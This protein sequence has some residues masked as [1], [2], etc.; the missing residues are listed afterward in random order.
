[1]KA[2]M[3]DLINQSEIRFHQQNLP[4]FAH[5]GNILSS[6]RNSQCLILQAE[7]GLGK[8]T[9]LPQYLL[10]EYAQSEYSQIY[11]TQPRKIAASGASKRVNEEFGSE[12]MATSCVYPSDFNEMSKF[13]IVYFSE[14]AFLNHLLSEI[15]N[16]VPLKN[17][18]GLVL[19]EAHERN[20]ET[21]VILALIKK[22]VLP[23]RPDFKLIITSATLQLE[24]LMNY[25]KCEIITIPGAM[26]PVEII[27]CKSY[28][29][30]FI[31]TVN[32]TIGVIKGKIVRS[33]GKETILVFFS[34]FDEINGAKN[35]ISNKV[36]L[37]NVEI[38]MLYGNLDFKEQ[39]DIVNTQS[40]KIRVVISTNI[41]ESSLTVP[42]VTCV[43]D[44][45]REKVSVS[46]QCKDYRVKF[47]TKM[48]A[49]QRKGRAGRTNPGVCYRVY[50]ENEYQEMLD[51]REPAIIKSHIGLLVLKFM[52]YGI[53]EIESLGLIDGPDPESIKATN[54]DLENL[55]MLMK[56]S[57][58]LNKITNIGNFCLDLEISPMLARFIYEAYFNYD[59][60]DEAAMLSSVLLCMDFIFLRTDYNEEIV[61]DM[62]ED[63][64]LHKDLVR[65]G[66]M[67]S[68]LFIFRQYY[69]L[70]CNSC[71]S[72]SPICTCAEIRKTW[73]QKFYICEKRIKVALKQYSDICNKLALKLQEH[74]YYF[75]EEEWA[76]EKQLAEMSL[77][78]TTSPR[79]QENLQAVIKNFEEFYTEFLQKAII[80]SF[81][82]NLAQY[83]GD[84]TID[85]GYLYIKTR[86]IVVNHP[87]SPLGKLMF[88]TP[89]KYV[90]F[91]EVSVTS[92]LFMKFITP[93]DIG[94]VKSICDNW[95]QS[96]NF[97]EEIEEP[98]GLVFQNIGPLYMREIFGPSGSKVQN[99][100]YSFK[101]KGINGVL[102]LPDV[103]KNCLKLRLP[104]SFREAGEQELRS[105]LNYKQTEVLRKNIVHIPFSKG[106]IL[107]IN[108]GGTVSELLYSEETLIFHLNDLK[109]YNNYSEALADVQ[110]TFE[111]Y[112][113]NYVKKFNENFGIVY[114][115]SVAQAEEAQKRLEQKPLI[116]KTGM[117]SQLVPY[118]KSLPQPCL[119]IR[120]AIQVNQLKSML[121]YYG[122]YKYINFKQLS[123]CAQAYIRY[124]SQNAT[125]SCFF[126]LSKWVNDEFGVQVSIQKLQ[127]GILVP[128]ELVNIG[129][130]EIVN[131]IEKINS[132]HDSDFHISGRNVM[133][134]YAEDQRLNMQ[135][136]EMIIDLVN[137]DIIPITPELMRCLEK[138]FITMPDEEN[139]TWKV[140]QQIYQVFCVF[141]H[142]RQS[143]A[144]YGLPHN[145]KY[146]IEQL[147]P[148]LGNLLKQIV[149]VTINYNSIKEM[150][151]IEL[152]KKKH[153]NELQVD[154]SIN[155]RKAAVSF[156]GIN[157]YINNVIE[158]L[159][160]E[161]KEIQNIENC[162][163]CT[164]FL[165][166]NIVI[167]S[168]CGHK[169]HSKCI[170]FQIKSSI[171]EAATGGFPIVCVICGHF[172]IHNDWCKALSYVELQALYH[173]ALIQFISNNEQFSH[174]ENPSCDFVY[175]VEQV[176]AQGNKR[177]CARC[178]GEYCIVCKKQI[179]GLGHE[180]NCEI[181]KMQIDDKENLKWIEEN[182]AVCPNCLVR[183]EKSK[184]CNHLNCPRCRTHFCFLCSMKID[185]FSPIEHYMIPNTK[186]FQK[187]IDNSH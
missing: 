48:S 156:T 77:N 54:T 11:C 23:K 106:M 166:E 39:Q 155:R 2:N 173:S 72:N 120:A 168:L 149:T 122:E 55:K 95:L 153:Y 121:E 14:Y 165:S 6:L 70:L 69:A 26:F 135:A 128:K 58:N 142:F 27:Y 145:R 181:K 81:F 150:R 112:Q 56:T 129:L 143:L 32:I 45:G 186:C 22:H 103:S 187:Y 185:E 64:L 139:V 3:Q 57:E 119:K 53:F 8:T 17:C 68:S 36:S 83:R 162:L 123:N 92:N 67:V 131:Y 110:N 85:A 29:N 35:I 177:K 60:G 101:K 125:D 61:E 104:A 174:C 21:D 180:I 43:V 37:E 50:T 71:L 179:F 134:I 33:T 9:Q 96:Q 138:H 127:Q 170:N 86:E 62:R 90:I 114:F 100:E 171:S 40:K 7:T 126:E 66:D 178:K 161:E 76:L 160:L 65:L 12:N 163:I 51:F 73:S 158:K 46:G 144:V 13:P 118:E 84:K 1:M 89:P 183:I 105:I 79:F 52:K 130:E 94:K 38:L 24:T 140:W 82:Q 97:S 146:A 157:Y 88:L 98:S 175:Q 18:K 159:K 74:V 109:N 136:R 137:Y 20:I 99:L 164:E 4:L 78:D 49:T 87:C 80:A 102:I 108:P 116:G 132:I 151:K 107:V 133:R 10:I 111:F 16:E 152:F 141:L 47:I 148:I 147:Q 115:K 169:F 124:S 41:A 44:C 42:G 28:D 59:C 117:V 31:E 172:L 30:Y 25:L 93:V 167:L 184:G 34:G 182:T 154:I 63:Y 5:R 15:Y 176:K 19:D 113:F 75:S 91:Y